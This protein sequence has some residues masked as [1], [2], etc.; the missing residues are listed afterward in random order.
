MNRLIIVGGSSVIANSIVNKFLEGNELIEVIKITRNKDFIND[1]KYIYIDNYSNLE[2]VFSN[3]QP[4]RG[5]TIILAF[6]YLG[7]TGYKNSYPASLDEDNQNRVFDI[8]FMQMKEALN[9][10]IKFL[11]ASGGDIIYL[12]SAAAYPVRN[13]NIPYGLSKKYIDQYIRQ[14]NYYLKK[15]NINILSVRL[16]F[17]N[18][19]LNIGRKS[20]PFSATPEKVAKITLRALN[21]NKTIVYIPTALYFVTKILLLFPKL[22]NYLDKKYS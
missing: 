19:P 4:S 12:S 11:K 1:K 22:T 9:C 7:L 14:Q 20:T 21:R 5:D 17:V 18:T 15:S 10:S 13:S 3:F 8:N 6:A 16:G 2:A